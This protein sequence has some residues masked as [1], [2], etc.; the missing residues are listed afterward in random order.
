MKTSYALL[1]LLAVIVAAGFAYTQR[2]GD[3]VEL[4]NKDMP[5]TPLPSD[6]TIPW[7]PE[8]ALGQPPGVEPINRVM[9]VTLKTNKGDIVIALDGTRAPLTVGNFVKLANDNFYDGTTFHRVIADFM[10]Q[11]G[12]P[13]SK[14]QSARD[15]HGTG[16]PGYQFKDEINANSYGLDTTKIV[17]VIDPSQVDQL[18]P[19]V[20]DWT[21]KQFYESQGYRYTT[22][23]ESLPL[24]R[25]V[26]AMANSG[27]NTNGSQ[28]FI[29]TAEA[30]SQLNGKHTPFGIVQQ[31]MDVVL[32]IQNV[33]KDA[34]DNPTD[35]VIIEDIIVSDAL[36][37][38]LDV[39]E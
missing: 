6:N 10:I 34:N 27:P 19:E 4:G 23:L 26:I 2:P 25:G 9:N 36:G 22:D 5:E 28:F 1:I 17:D 3:D 7:P 21:I 20:K 15:K 8:A 29:I 39:I 24:Q 31:G 38:G 16:G 18:K 35:P 33:P 37:A 32:A 30:V 11:G 12:D 13:N 14:D